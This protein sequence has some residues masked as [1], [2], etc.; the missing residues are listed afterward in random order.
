MTKKLIFAVLTALLIVTSCSQSSDLTNAIP[1]DANYV[2]KVNTKSLIAKSQYDIFENQTVKQGINMYKAFLKDDDKIKL[3]DAFLKDAN[4]LGVNL[5]NDAYF[6]T[7][8]SVFGFVLGTNNPETLKD[9]F[10][11]LSNLDEEEITKENDIYSISKSSDVAIVW[12]SNKIIFLID[13]GYTLGEQEDQVDLMTQAKELLVQ[14]ADKSI[15][16][17]KSFAEFAKEDGDI[18]AFVTMTSYEKFEKLASLSGGGLTALNPVF[19][20]TIKEV[21]GCSLGTI[22]SFEKGE[23]TAQSKYYFDTPETEKKVKELTNKVSGNIKGDHL[24]YLTSEPVFAASINIKGEG[25]HSYLKD[26][27]IIDM[28]SKEVTDVLTT[29]QVDA[30][31]KGCNG[32]ATLAVTDF[33]VKQD[34]N[35][36]RPDVIPNCFFILDIANP[37][38][39]KD[40]I[41]KQIEENSLDCKTLSDGQFL[42]EP[43]ENIKVYFGLNKNTFFITNDESVYKNLNADLKNNYTD[44]IKGKSAIAIG[45]VDKLRPVMESDYSLKKMA[46]Y[47]SMFNKYQYTVNSGDL[48]AHGKLELAKKEKNSLAQICSDID[49]A[50]SE[51]GSIF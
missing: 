36:Y 14:G 4:S 31:I 32:D 29:E 44:L 22:I 7:N 11:K 19:A 47:I 15:N 2:V 48:A 17:N 34:E 50:I 21:E 24:K 10:M 30:L 13:G 1:A 27:G 8:Y 49:N 16:S 18:T 9:A 28:I 45:N 42:F 51:L 12:N 6:F 37:D 40:I 23:I 35:A 38:Q 43:K 39:I 46:P 26:A 41:K 20:K 3:L 5:K 33:I 25:I